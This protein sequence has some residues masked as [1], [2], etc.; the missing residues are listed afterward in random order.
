M[1]TIR[2]SFSDIRNQYGIN[3]ENQVS[4]AVISSVHLYTDTH[5][6]VIALIFLLKQ[7]SPI[8]LV[9]HGSVSETIRQLIY[10][11]IQDIKE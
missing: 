10:K 9:F 11:A 8:V 5:L 2:I 7:K 1:L 4:K 6:D 3:I